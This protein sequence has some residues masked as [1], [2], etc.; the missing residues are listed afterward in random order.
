MNNELLDTY[1]ASFAEKVSLAKHQRKKQKNMIEQL[2]KI[3]EANKEQEKKNLTMDK[4]FLSE[5]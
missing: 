1:M 2:A 4:A 3:N 5:I